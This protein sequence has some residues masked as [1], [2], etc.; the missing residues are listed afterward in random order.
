MHLTSSLTLLFHA[1][2]LIPNHKLQPNG[3]DTCA[4]TAFLFSPMHRYCGNTQTRPVSLPTTPWSAAH[5]VQIHMWP[6][7]VW[8]SSTQQQRRT[9]SSREAATET[10]EGVGDGGPTPTPSSHP[11]PRTYDQVWICGGRGLLGVLCPDRIHMNSSNFSYTTICPTPLPDSSP[12]CHTF[13][14]LTLSLVN[15]SWTFLSRRWR[16]T[17]LRSICVR[18]IYTDTWGR[19]RACLCFFP[20]QFFNGPLTTKTSRALLKGSNFT[21]RF[22]SAG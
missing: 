18:N 6:N 1:S 7:G 3:L 19:V 9:R 16:P 2:S 13:S 22:L 10:R 15:D 11:S 20:L 12:G 21:Q 5:A 8:R 4:N 14:F 17:L